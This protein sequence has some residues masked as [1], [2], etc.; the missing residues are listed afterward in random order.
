MNLSINTPEEIQEV[1]DG[2][3]DL[4][5]VDRVI[6]IHCAGTMILIAQQNKLFPQ[7]MVDAGYGYLIENGIDLPAATLLNEVLRLISLLDNAGLLEYVHLDA[8]DGLNALDA[9]LQ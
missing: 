9:T 5:A 8:L 4:P 6:L 7:E 2:E 1:L 3:R